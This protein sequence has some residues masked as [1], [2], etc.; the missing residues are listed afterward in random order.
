V[1]VIPIGWFIFSANLPMTHFMLEEKKKREDL[2]SFKDYSAGLDAKKEVAEYQFKKDSLL[3]SEVSQLLK[4][5][6]IDSVLTII[7]K[8]DLVTEKIKKGLF[9]LDSLVKVKNTKVSVDPVSNN[10]QPG[11]VTSCG[12]Y[13]E[14]SERYLSVDEVMYKPSRTLRLM[15]NEIFMRHNFIF[16][17]Q[18]LANYASSFA[19]YEPLHS[20]VGNLLTNIERTNIELIQRYEVENESA[21]PGEISI[22]IPVAFPVSKIVAEQ[23]SKLWN[24]F[25]K[26]NKDL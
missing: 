19:C 15:R 8:N 22:L 25:T 1:C 14:S 18:D 24:S 21:I 2:L 20:D 6:N 3:R 12:N 9:S 11:R 5:D 7:R 16:G 10:Y 26:D 17:N 13:P 4:D 23:V